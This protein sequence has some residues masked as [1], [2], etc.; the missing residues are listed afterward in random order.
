MP[1]SESLR[2][3]PFEG[4]KNAFASMYKSELLDAK[5]YDIVYGLSKRLGIAQYDLQEL[6]QRNL[7]WGLNLS[8]LKNNYALVEAMDSLQNSQNKLAIVLKYFV[9]PEIITLLAQSD[10]EHQK[11]YN[12]F[13]NGE[14]SKQ[15]QLLPANHIHFNEL[16]LDASLDLALNNSMTLFDPSP[17][18]LSVWQ[19][20]WRPRFDTV[21]FLQK[22]L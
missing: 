22:Y 20:K 14:M 13:I 18:A 11:K 19:E 4:E 16:T 10:L 7:V 3:T 21:N 5:R 9:S 15:L 6:L 1:F 2:Q 8:I 12:L 17:T